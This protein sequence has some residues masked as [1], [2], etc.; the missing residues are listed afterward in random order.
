MIQYLRVFDKSCDTTLKLPRLKKKEPGGMKKQV[1]T[2]WHRRQT[3]IHNFNRKRKK[4]ISYGILYNW[5]DVT[6]SVLS[7]RSHAGM[8]RVVQ[9]LG[10]KG[11]FFLFDSTTYTPPRSRQSLIRSKPRLNFVL[12]SFI[13][14][15][16]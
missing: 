15:R 16:K 4:G 1:Q 11:N 6:S 9:K 8:P 3:T 10:I 2:L 14:H 7:R 13:P 5:K 12:S